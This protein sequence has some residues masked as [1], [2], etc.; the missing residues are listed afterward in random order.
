MSVKDD[1]LIFKCSQQCNKNHDKYFNEGLI[2]RFAS[3]YEFCDGDINKF[4]LLSRKRVYPYEYMDSW[5]RLDE[6]SL[7]KKI[8][9]VV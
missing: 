7:P 5:E 2:N 3:T 6:T 8:F 4:I 1:Q 9:I